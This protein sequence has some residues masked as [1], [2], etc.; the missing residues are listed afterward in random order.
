MRG[1]L[2]ASP[3]EGP[4]DTAEVPATVGEGV[5]GVYV[6]PGFEASGLLV[7][8]PLRG[9]V[10]SRPGLVLMFPHISIE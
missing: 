7:V 2:H 6:I 3:P 9:E 10:P 1:V 8:R 4:V 5:G